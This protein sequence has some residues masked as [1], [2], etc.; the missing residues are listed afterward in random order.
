METNKGFIERETSYTINTR[1]QHRQNLIKQIGWHI[2]N[3]SL[4]KNISLEDICA[5]CRLSET[6]VKRWILGRGTIHID[7]LCRIFLTYN[8]KICIN[9]KDID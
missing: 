3:I 6:T 2:C 1:R 9:I 5:E 8:K 7:T 4:E